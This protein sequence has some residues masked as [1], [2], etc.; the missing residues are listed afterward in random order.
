MKTAEEMFAWVESHTVDILSNTE[1]LGKEQYRWIVVVWH[2]GG[3]SS[4][5]ANSLDVAIGY[6]IN[7]FP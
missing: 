7:E 5:Y 4:F 1:R 2:E 3:P 6:A